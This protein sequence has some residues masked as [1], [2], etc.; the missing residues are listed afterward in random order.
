MAELTPPPTVSPATPAAGRV[1]EV[2]GRVPD[3]V[4]LD[5]LE[6]RWDEAWTAAG[7]VP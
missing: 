5:G 4:S 7:P 2:S 3:K 1:P 6:Q